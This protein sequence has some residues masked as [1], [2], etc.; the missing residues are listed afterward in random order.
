MFWPRAGSLGYPA[1]RCMAWLV[2]CCGS[3]W[4]G[5]LPCLGSVPC[6]N[7]AGRWWVSNCPRGAGARG[8][9]SRCSLAL[10]VWPGA[11]RRAFWR[12][13]DLL[14]FP[15][16]LWL[17]RFSTGL[18]PIPCPTYTAPVLIGMAPNWFTCGR[19]PLPRV[20]WLLFPGGLALLAPLSVGAVLALSPWYLGPA[21]PLR[22]S[23]P[24][25]TPG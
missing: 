14:A 5:L 16:P 18:A 4:P 22:F 24:G 7:P 11:A 6:C 9:S 15:C 8:L 13:P 2:L 25:P 19:W 17:A 10:L 1:R 23:G 21:M 20:G 3:R 12:T